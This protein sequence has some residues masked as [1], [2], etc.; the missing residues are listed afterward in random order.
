MEIKTKENINLKSAVLKHQIALE[1]VELLYGREESLK[2]EIEIYTILA[3]V[4]TLSEN[5][6][7]EECNQDKRNLIDIMEQEIEPIFLQLIEGKEYYDLYKEILD[8]VNLYCHKVYEENHSLIGMLNTITEAISSLEPEQVKEV[9]T[10]TGEVAGKVKEKE[11]AQQKAIEDKKIKQTEEVND[12]LQQLI[13]K[14]TK[15]EE[16]PEATE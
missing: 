9:L 11:L 7:I 10:K 16:T 5:N 12:K 14:F 15:I 6:L 1:A 8:D 3:F 2:T 4:D 13:N